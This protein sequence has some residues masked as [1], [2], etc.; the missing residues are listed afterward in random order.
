M[1]AEILVGVSSSGKSTYA[2]LLKTHTTICRDDTRFSVVSPEANGWKTYKFSKENED[3][4][5]DINEQALR[6]CAERKESVVIAD[7]NL[8][9]KFRRKLIEQLQ[10]LGYEVKLVVFH[11]TLKHAIERDSF[12]GK[13]SVGEEVIKRQWSSYEQLGKPLQE[14]INKYKIEIKDIEN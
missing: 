13:Y 12:R 6:G 4:V 5:T 10:S 3:L 8:N 2:G 9:T 14:E 1:K 11:V 7:T